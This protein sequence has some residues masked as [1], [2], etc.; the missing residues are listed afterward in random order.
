MKKVL[1]IYVVLIAAIAV[2][3]FGFIREK[4]NNNDKTKDHA[5]AV[6]KHSK[7]FNKSLEKMMDAYY[8]MTEYFVKADTNSINKYATELKLAIGELKIDDLKKDT[9]IYE[10]AIS[11]WEN[12]KTEIE[13]MMNDPSLQAKRESLNLFSNELFTLLLTIHYDL[14]KLYWQECPSAF[15]EE[16]PGNW[17][18]QTEKST[19]PYVKENCGEVKKTINLVPADSTKNKLPL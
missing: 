13:G 6:S 18:S 2:T 1:L 7:E 10:T 14:A 15:G 5:L 4:G 12:A 3:Y 16:T 11:I 9:V 8:S 19:N 17:I